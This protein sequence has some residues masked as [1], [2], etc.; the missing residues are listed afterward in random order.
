MDIPSTH[1]SLFDVLK[2]DGCRDRAWLAFD[3]AYRPVILSW[4]ERKLDGHLAED[5]TQEIL[6][7]LWRD[8]PKQQHDPQKGHFRSWLK[9]VVNNALR[10]VWRRQQTRPQAP[11]V[12]GTEFSEKIQNWLA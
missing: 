5:L 7:R 8:L 4:L 9:A 3:T 1:L 10:D 12:G 6:V 11:A 2:D